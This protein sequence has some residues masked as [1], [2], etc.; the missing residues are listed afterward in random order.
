MDLIQSIGID[1]IINIAIGIIALV[2]GG[3]WLFS[4]AKLKQL[5]EALQAV[6]DAIEDNKVSNEEEK[7]IVSKFKVLLKK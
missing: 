6:S 5:I 7:A 1:N 2:A 4:K 3:A